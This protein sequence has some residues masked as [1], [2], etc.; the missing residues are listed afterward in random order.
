MARTTWALRID[1]KT[2]KACWAPGS[3][4]YTTV[5]PETSRSRVDEQPG[6]LDRDE[7][8]VGAVQDEEVR[9]VL[10][11]AQQ[12]SAGLED[13]GVV[14]PALLQDPRREEPVAHLLG[15]AQ[16]GRAGEVV[17]AVVRHGDRDAGVGVLEAGLVRRVVRRSRAASAVRWPPAEPPVIAM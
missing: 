15:A 7:G 9:R 5:A 12:G 10:G 11:D 13:L 4:A 6:L 14:R 17:D 3:S 16:P 2:S 8:V 1:G